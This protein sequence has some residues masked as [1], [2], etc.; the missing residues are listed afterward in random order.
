M[1][2][3]DYLAQ[4]KP[5]LFGGAMGAWRAAQPDWAGARCE[6]ANLNAAKALLPGLSMET[7]QAGGESG[8]VPHN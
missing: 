5:L 7:L 1:N 6:L 8:L 4:G 3:R 2:I